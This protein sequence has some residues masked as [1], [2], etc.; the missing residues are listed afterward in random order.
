MTRIIKVEFCDRCPNL[1]HGCGEP[2]R[3]RAM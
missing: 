3:C 1:L 2:L